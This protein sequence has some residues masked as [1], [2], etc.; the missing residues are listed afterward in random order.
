MPLSHKYY[1][2]KQSLTTIGDCYGNVMITI[3][4]HG[5]LSNYRV[6][7][8]K[9]KYLQLYQPPMGSVLGLKFHFLTFENK[10]LYEVFDGNLINYKKQNCMIFYKYI[11]KY[12]KTLT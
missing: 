12:F 3:Q 1:K 4:S 7:S 11:K 6:L 8:S 10:I 5:Q 2:K 9:G